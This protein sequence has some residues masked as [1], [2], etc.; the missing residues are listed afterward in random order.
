[1]INHEFYLVSIPVKNLYKLSMINDLKNI[2][3]P[4][5]SD[6]IIINDKYVCGNYS[7]LK[8]KMEKYSESYRHLDEW[9]LLTF[10]DVAD[11]KNK[12]IEYI[13]EIDLRIQKNTCYICEYNTYKTNNF[14]KHLS[15]IKHKEKINLSISNKYN[16]LYNSKSNR[17]IINTNENNKKIYECIRCNYETEIK[18]NY[19]RHLQTINHIIKENK[20]TESQKDKIMCEY[21]NKLFNYR[22]SLSRHR[23]YRCKKLK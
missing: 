21:C 5:N 18:S 7:I 4:C 15:S 13:N 3:K 2:S 12:I 16:D 23:L 19:K 14:K 6:T 22:S 20:N 11:Y 17:A 9:V 8:S 1:M 10:L